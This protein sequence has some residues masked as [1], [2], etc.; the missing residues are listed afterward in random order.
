VSLGALVERLGEL[1]DERMR[2]ACA[3]LAVAVACDP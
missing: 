3:A 1:G 2:E